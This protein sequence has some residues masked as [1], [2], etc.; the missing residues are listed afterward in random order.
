MPTFTMNEQN[1]IGNGSIPPFVQYHFVIF[2]HH[3]LAMFVKSFDTPH[4]YLLSFDYLFSVKGM[5]LFVDSYL[6]LLFYE[7]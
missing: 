3:S 5:M 7:Y 4:V 1:I 6:Y 2:V